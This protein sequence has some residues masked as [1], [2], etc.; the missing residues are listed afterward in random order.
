[1]R[2]CMC[3]WMQSTHPH[4][5]S[6]CFIFIFP[7]S[8]LTSSKWCLPFMF[9]NYNSIRIFQIAMHAIWPV[10]LNLLDHFSA[11]WRRV[12]SRNYSILRDF[13][14]GCIFNQNTEERKQLKYQ[15]QKA[16]HPLICRH[17]WTLLQYVLYCNC[18]IV[19][20]NTTVEMMF[21]FLN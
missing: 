18:T 21:T 19:Y 15:L 6:V 10:G 9:S 8:M 4:N 20:I 13:K 11:V 1:V 16:Q 12:H 2:A 14:G 3:G 17:C 7:S 5:V